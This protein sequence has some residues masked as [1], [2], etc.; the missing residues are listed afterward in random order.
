MHTA[1]LASED[2]LAIHD[3]LE[4]ARGGLELVEVVVH[5]G[6]VALAL[7]QHALRVDGVPLV[8]HDTNGHSAMVQQDEPHT[9]WVA[10][11]LQCLIKTAFLQC[12]PGS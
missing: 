12:M 6:A 3:V 5:E 10:H 11:T 4:H 2:E 7:A 8:L 9:A 1:A